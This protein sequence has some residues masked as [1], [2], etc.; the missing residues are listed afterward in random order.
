MNQSAWRLN[1]DPPNAML[2]MH[3]QL[4][5][6]IKK[7][8]NAQEEPMID[9]STDILSELAPTGR[10]RAALNHGNF[11]LVARDEARRPYGISV[12]LATAF[13]AA[14]GLELDFIEYERAVDVSSSATNGA[15]DICFLAV[16]PKRAETIDF[17]TPY[18]RIDGRYLAGAHCDVSDSDALVASGAAVGSVEGSAYT[19]TLQRQPGAENL[20]T[21]T[22]IH[23]ALAALDAGK[24]AA[25]AGI[26][27]AMAHEA[28]K[29]QGTRVLS[30][31]FMEIRQAMALPQGRPSASRVLKGWLDGA[32]RSGLTGDILERYGVARSCAIL[33][34]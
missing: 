9:I 23:A 20:I 19:L 33:P 1:R 10:L 5:Q 25:I 8:R 7:V 12:D 3:E 11:V 30:P 34:S 21:Y 22:D 14:V 16:D 29:R 32:A 15:W 27:D 24:V 2:S 4:R 28:S 18:I 26:G 13:A 6:G 17:T 31:P